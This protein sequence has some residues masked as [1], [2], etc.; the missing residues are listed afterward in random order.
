MLNY[1][2]QPIK[3][4]LSRVQTWMGDAVNRINVIGSSDVAKQN[5]SVLGACLSFKMLYI[6]IYIK[7]YYCCYYTI[8]INATIYMKYLASS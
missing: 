4:K 1:L 3:F 5:V 6:Y 2:D 7:L 8:L